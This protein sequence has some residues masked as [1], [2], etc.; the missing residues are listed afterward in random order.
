[1]TSFIIHHN[2]LFLS[3]ITRYLPNNNQYNLEL[4]PSYLFASRYLSYDPTVPPVD[5]TSK[6]ILS[7]KYIELLKCME[8]VGFTKEVITFNID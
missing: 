2:F 6:K 3:E 8:S 1:M 5:E 7:E 4:Q